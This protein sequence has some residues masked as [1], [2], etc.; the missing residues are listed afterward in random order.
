MDTSKVEKVPQ[1]LCI[2]FNYKANGLIRQVGRAG[3]G[4]SLCDDSTPELRLGLGL[5]LGLG[6]GLV[7]GLGLGLGIVFGLGLGIVFGLGSEFNP[8]WLIHFELLLIQPPSPPAE[9]LHPV[10]LYSFCKLFGHFLTKLYNKEHY[11]SII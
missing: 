4:T 9:K 1:I 8:A 5:V 6:L 3:V 10:Y 2:G 11:F 7:L